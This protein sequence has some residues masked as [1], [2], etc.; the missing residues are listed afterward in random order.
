MHIS[1]SFVIVC[2]NIIHCIVFYFVII[3]VVLIFNTFFFILSKFTTSHRLFRPPPPVYLILPNVSTLRLLGP[4]VYSGPKSNYEN[5]PGF[6]MNLLN[7]NKRA[8]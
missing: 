4:P 6:H 5:L 8:H 3:I 2:Y 7:N 1:N